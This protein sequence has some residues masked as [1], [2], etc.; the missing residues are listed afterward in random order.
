MRSFLITTVATRFEAGL[1]VLVPHEAWIDYWQFFGEVCT[2]AYSLVI[3]L[4]RRSFAAAWC[5]H[6]IAVRVR[7]SS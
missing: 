3:P 1:K 5:R 7:V 2:F 6:V 4:L